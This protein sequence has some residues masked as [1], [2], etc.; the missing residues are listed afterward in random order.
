MNFNLSGIRDT[1]QWIKVIYPL[2]SQ[3]LSFLLCHFHVI[4]NMPN[5]WPHWLS[6]YWELSTAYDSNFPSERINKS[7]GDLDFSS[8]NYFTLCTP[9][10]HS[11]SSYFVRISQRQS[12]WTVHFRSFSQ[13]SAHAVFKNSLLYPPL[14]LS[15][16]RLF[17]EAS[18]LSSRVRV[19]P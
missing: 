4:L 18:S 10:P 5:S 15:I 11:S 14:P 6:T 16:A 19:H 1:C 7:Q 9:R 8:I 3:A 13:C 17:F 12:L 2:L